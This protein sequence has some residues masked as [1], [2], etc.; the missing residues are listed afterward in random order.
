MES[1]IN[2]R[3]GKFTIL[4]FDHYDKYKHEF[5]KC[6]C[7]CGN[8]FIKRKD[9]I[10]NSKQRPDMFKH[11]LSNTRFDSIRQGMIQRC[12]NNNNPY[13]KNYGGRNIKVCNEW[14][15][16]EN[17]LLNFYN[18]SINNGYDKHLTLDRIDVNGNY[19]PSNCRWVT[20]KVQE[21]NRRTNHC[22]T[23]NGIKKTIQQWCEYFGIKY[24]TL[25]YHLVRRKKSMYTI[26]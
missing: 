5:Y 22:V 6:K 20:I 17:G 25:F 24:D 7:D 15:D 8:I 9:I 16:K 4:N 13:Y 14:L 11:G 12:Y 19:E 10:L 1:I 23:Y 18:W 2:K 3:I 21:N 26:I